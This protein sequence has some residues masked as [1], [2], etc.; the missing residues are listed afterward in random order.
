MYLISFQI[1]VITLIITIVIELGI[2]KLIMQ[3]F[4]RYNLRYFWLSLISVN[5]ATNPAFNIFLTIFDPTRKYILLE[6]GF[7]L[8]IIIIEAGLLYLIYRKEFNKLLLLST[9]MNLISYGIGLLI[10]RPIWL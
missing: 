5:L 4:K 1:L 7:E 6:I 3:L 9:I 10:F 8:S 2:W